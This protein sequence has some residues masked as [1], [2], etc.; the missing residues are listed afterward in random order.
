MRAQIE[1]SHDIGISEAEAGRA[2]YVW[3]GSGHTQAASS[4]AAL[5]WAYLM[6]G[7]Y[8][9]GLHARLCRACLAWSGR[10]EKRPYCPAIFSLRLRAR[11]LHSMKIPDSGYC[12]RGGGVVTLQ[13]EI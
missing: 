7:S 4:Y 8:A 6:N 10:F 11:F 5:A 13:Q 1:R 2:L 9:A 12:G 3:G